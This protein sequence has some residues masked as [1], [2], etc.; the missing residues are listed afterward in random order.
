MKISR[1]S[2]LK[3]GA[4]GVASAAGGAVVGRE[5]LADVPSPSTTGPSTAR[6]SDAVAS[7]SESVPFRG[8]HQAGIDTPVQPHA[9]FAAFDV[10]QR[11][12]SAVKALLRRWTAL[13]ES[14]STAAV[15]EFDSG[16]TTGLGPSRLT[17]T[18]GFSSAFFDDLCAP[19]AAKPEGL[20]DLPAFDGD[21]LEDAWNGGDIAVQVCADDVTVASHAVRQLRRVGSGTASLRWMQNGFV[22]V[23]AGKTPRNLFGQVDGTANPAPGTSGFDELVWAGHDVGQAWMAGGTFMGI[24]RIR[25]GLTM[26]D[27][28]GV[29]VHDATVGRSRITGA[30]LSGGD[31]F[32]PLD[33]E[34]EDSDGSPLIASDAH[35]R[36]AKLAGPGMLRRGYSFD[37][38]RRDVSAS[39]TDNSAVADP[40]ADSMDHSDHPMSGHAGMAG[41]A[42]TMD[43]HDAGLMF[44][45]FVANPQTQFIAVQQALSASDGL[46][47]FLGYT[48][49]SLWAV[50]GG[51]AEGSIGDG[52]FE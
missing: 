50:P 36:V 29:D 51:R 37:N 44:V 10:S 22:P 32:T 13:A 2:L 52:I 25:M 43:D 38:G 42:A 39:S 12:Q 21:V 1:R 6:P 17:I 48:S 33:F 34:K 16:E 11:D 19:A 26:W 41:M 20:V 28:M 24:R 18:F 4:L 31:E 7:V 47:H 14:L 30:P 3:G 15:D 9:V 8:V 5:W 23:I 35:A 46:G 40:K 27:R 45:A 49:A